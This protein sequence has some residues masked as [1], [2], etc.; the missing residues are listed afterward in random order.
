M[1]QLAKNVSFAYDQDSNTKNIRITK[2]I[3][4]AVGKQSAVRRNRAEAPPQS[5]KKAEG[6][7]AD[8]FK[9]EFDPAQLEKRK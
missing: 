4:L 1:K 6:P 5:S 3:V 9:F 2:V 8:P 7:P